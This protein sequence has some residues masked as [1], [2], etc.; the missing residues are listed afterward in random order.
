MQLST[1]QCKQHAQ[2]NTIRCGITQQITV[3]WNTVALY[4]VTSHMQ[5]GKV[6]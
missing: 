1:V 4:C 5:C 2:C 6:W 3:K